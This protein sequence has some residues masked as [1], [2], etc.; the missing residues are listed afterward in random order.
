MSMKTIDAGMVQKCFLAGAK[1]I[2][3]N[4]EYI[5]ELNRYEVRL[6]CPCGWMS[7]VGWGATRE[8]AIDKAFIKAKIRVVEK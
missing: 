1:R 4:K 7:P 3:A 2:E 8:E 6:F 5:N